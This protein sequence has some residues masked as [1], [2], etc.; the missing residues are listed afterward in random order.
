[1]L[2]L[3]R[4]KYLQTSFS[5]TWNV[6]RNWRAEFNVLKLAENSKCEPRFGGCPEL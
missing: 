1:M 4:F 6:D 3:D 5:L 2:L